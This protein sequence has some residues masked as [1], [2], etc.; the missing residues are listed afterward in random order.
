MSP[1]NTLPWNTIVAIIGMSILIPSLLTI[2]LIRI[3]RF[4][5]VGMAVGVFFLIL[6]SVSYAYL[7]P[8]EIIHEAT[9]PENYIWQDQGA[10]H[11]WERNGIFQQGKDQRPI[12]FALRRILPQRSPIDRNF[13]ATEVIHVSEVDRE[14]N[15]ALIR[16]VIYDDSGEI[17]NVINNTEKVSEWYWIDSHTSSLKYL[18]VNAGYMGIPSVVNG[19]NKLDVGWVDSNGEQNGKE[20]VVLIRDMQRIQTG[21]INGVE[22]SV[23]QSDI[24][25]KPITWHGKPYFCDETF[26]L[27][28]NPTTGY[29]IHVYRHL[30]LSAYLSQF[31]KLYYPSSLNSRVVTNYLKLN[32]PIG[33]AA[34]LIYD[35]TVDSQN[36]HLNEARDINNLITYVPLAICI[37]IVLIGIALTWRYCGRSYYWKRYKEYEQDDASSQRKTKR[38]SSRTKILAIGMCSILL[39]SSIGYFVYQNSSNQKTDLQIPPING[40]TLSPAEEKEPTPPGTNRVIDSGRH[41]LLPIDEGAHKS[42]REWWYF[43]VFFNDP[44]S[45]LQGYSMIVSFNKMKFLDMR[46]I[47]PDNLFILLFDDSGKSYNFDT[48]SKRRGTLQ[49][50]SNGVDVTFQN[51]WAKGSYPSW[52]VHVVNDEKGFVADLQF[53]ADFLP[54]WVEGNSANLAIAKQIEGDYYV[55]RCTVTGNMTLDGKQYRVGGIGYHDH[56]WENIFPRSISKGWDWANLHFDNG[57]EM[58]VSKFILRT[59]FKLSFDSIIVS[60]NNRNITEFN[61]FDV[62]YTETASPKG[63]P[64]M[65]YP[66]KLH[67][68]AKRDDMILKL[69][70]EVYNTCENVWKWARTGM[71][72]GPCYAKGTFSWS[73]QTVEL[74]GYGLSEFTRV[75]YLF[76][77]PGIFRK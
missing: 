24:Y 34:E 33:E 35:T 15:K 49:A 63:L 36:M 54:V 68:E 70:I 61:H 73:D 59:P 16:D 76:G 19:V 72:E 43:N 21:F 38:K 52:Q 45:D 74:N 44:G 28:V 56:V 5:D 69:D 3:K 13:L 37:P 12:P 26:Q 50:T 6:G 47:R 18:S 17:L 57:W 10:V 67:I 77:L 62:T 22:V 39:F 7:I 71:F 58:Y 23:W 65:S 42:R 11:Y 32:D 30:V 51:S 14:A 20:N 2:I 64:F 48:L 60:P 4:E 75:K 66:K 9:L 40:N 53:T 55:P 8:Q 27:T 25:N 46:F 1:L 31:L 41:I 29:V